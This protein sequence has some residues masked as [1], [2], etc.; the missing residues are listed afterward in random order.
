[1]VSSQSKTGI[2]SKY[3]NPRRRV[4]QVNRLEATNAVEGFEG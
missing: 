2:N 4:E 3:L 1:M